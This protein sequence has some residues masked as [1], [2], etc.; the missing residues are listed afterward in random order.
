M[1]LENEGP[2]ATQLLVNN[3][4]LMGITL[5]EWGLRVGFGMR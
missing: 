2:N 5:P 4:V 1:A 3:S